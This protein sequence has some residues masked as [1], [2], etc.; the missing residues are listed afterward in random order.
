M[1]MTWW[2]EIIRENWYLLLLLLGAFAAA[3][4]MFSRESGTSTIQAQPL[5]TAAA[6][7]PAPPL[8]NVQQETPT[9]ETVPIAGATE[10]ETAKLKIA[11]YQ[12]KLDADPKNPDAASWLIAMSYLSYQKLMDYKEAARYL[13]LVIVDHPEFAGTA[14]IYPQL[15]TCYERMG[16]KAGAQRVYREMV[17]KFPE[18]TPERQYANMQLGY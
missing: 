14:R 8:I 15:A 13:E 7:A 2:K 1:T 18:G 3:A 9:G 6:P 16:D 10:E 4:V 12:K 5:D 17:H 11:D